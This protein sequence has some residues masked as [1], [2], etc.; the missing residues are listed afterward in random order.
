[1]KPH[2][3]GMLATLL[4]IG[5]STFTKRE[6][7]RTP[8][9]YYFAFDKNNGDIADPDDVSDLEFWKYTGLYSNTLPVVSIDCET[10][11]FYEA[12]EIAIEAVLLDENYLEIGDPLSEVQNAGT[13]ILA[14]E[15][16]GINLPYYILDESPTMGVFAVFNKDSN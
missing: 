14:V 2:F 8:E 12:C 7:Q 6:K 4:A 13:I 16:T 5:V 11:E 10:P 15:T 1:M 3:W 9:Y